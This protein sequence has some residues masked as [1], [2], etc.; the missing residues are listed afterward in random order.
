MSKTKISEAYQ[1]YLNE[2]KK[3]EEKIGRFS[4]ISR[5]L[6]PMS[7]EDFKVNL[8]DIKIQ[9]ADKGSFISKNEIARRLAQLETYTVSTEQ[10]IGLKKSGLGEY[11]DLSVEQIRAKGISEETINAINEERKMLRESMGVD[12]MTDRDQKANANAAIS[13]YI[14]QH[15]F[16]SL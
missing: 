2:R 16:G 1:I 7:I 4:G 12:L 11:K 13:H 14:S 15:Y 6:E 5:D 8:K 9:Y 3:I 10:A